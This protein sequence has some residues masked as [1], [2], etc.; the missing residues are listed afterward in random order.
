MPLIILH[1][2]LNVFV[3]LANKRGLK[4]IRETKLS[5]LHC[6]ATVLENEGRQSPF[7]YIIITGLVLQTTCLTRRILS[8]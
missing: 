2:L 1:H 5:I 6:H 7:L 3:Q 8:M 4:K